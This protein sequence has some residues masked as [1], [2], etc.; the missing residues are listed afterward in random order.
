MPHYAGMKSKFLFFFLLIWFYSCAQNNG[1]HKADPEAIKLNN[2]AIQMVDRSIHNPDSCQKAIQL[3][4]SATAIDSLYY[5]AYW[6]KLIFQ[7]QLKQ[8]GKAILT[9]THLI[10]IKPGAP[11]LYV[12]CGVL[13]DR[14]G[15]TLSAANYYQKALTLYNQILDTLNTTN[16]NY[17][18]LF[19]NKATTL[20]LS[21]QKEKGN[22]LL[23]Q[24]YDRQT[25]EDFKKMTFALLNKDKKELLSLTAPE[26]YDSSQS[27]QI[28]PVNP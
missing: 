6:D 21:G 12:T 8:F 28:K 11:D 14:T 1:R 9:V 23:K 3:L 26:I 22:E 18:M 16:Q 27:V 5:L 4:D 7:Y 15:D 20:V 13:Y 24:L 17:D 25:D 10:G 2:R 19:A